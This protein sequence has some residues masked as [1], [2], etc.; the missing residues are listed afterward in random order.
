LAKVGIGPAATEWR[1]MRAIHPPRI[2]HGAM[3]LS[4]LNSLAGAAI[5][6]TL[7]PRQRRLADQL[8]R[9]LNEHLRADSETALG[10][11][12]HY[13]DRTSMA[14]GV[15]SRMPFLDVR[16]AE[17]LASM[18]E[19]YKINAGWTKFIARQ[20]FD[21]KL[22]D[23]IV[24]RKDKMGWPIPEQKWA[25]DDLRDW[26]AA[27]ARDAARFAEWGVGDEYSACLNSDDITRRIRALNLS[28][29]ARTFVD[30]E[31]R[32]RL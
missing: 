29:W 7:L 27:P 24:W 17:F 26:F 2:A 11:L 4:G 1:A 5:T 13:A 6:G 20:A 18:P 28:A 9:G 23:D 16:L 15:E 25:N 32:R 14:F 21:K 10:N 31:W 8:G 30:G 12:I 3:L 22:P 19:A